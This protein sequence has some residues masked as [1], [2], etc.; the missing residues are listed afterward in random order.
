[1]RA[2]QR[3]ARVNQNTDALAIR[4][5]RTL[6]KVF[7]PIVRQL[8]N[9]YSVF[10]GLYSE[11]RVLTAD[12]SYR[13]LTTCSFM[14]HLWKIYPL[15]FERSQAL[16]GHISI[17]LSLSAVLLAIIVTFDNAPKFL[18]VAA[19]MDVIF[20]SFL[21]VLS[22]RGLRV[23]AFY[24]SYSSVREY[25]HILWRDLAHKYSLLMLINTLSIV[26]IF[27]S[28]SLIVMTILNQ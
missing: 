2:L 6:D 3:K 25:R 8:T 27:A 20:K 22:L 10:V 24:K 12:C 18:V 15:T 9:E 16:V 28:V 4:I 13:K 17:M 19:V 21:M 23:H 5:N 1:M 11:Y 14:D 7:D 26:G